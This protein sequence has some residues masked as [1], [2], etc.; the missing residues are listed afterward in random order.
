MNKAIAE[1]IKQSSE[2]ETPVRV[3][4]LD[5]DLT[6]EVADLSHTKSRDCLS[7]LTCSSG[8]PF[9]SAMD[10]GPHGIMR[11]VNYGLRREVL[12]SNTIWLCVGC[13][14][15]SACCPMGIDI[16]AVMDALRHIALREG[17]KPAEPNVLTFHREVLNSIMR[18]GRTHKLEIMLR[19]KLHSGT[20]LKDVG[21]G[22][23]MMAKHKLDLR[24]SKIE[25]PDDLSPLFGPIWRGR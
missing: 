19:Y 18:Y 22:L 21:V 16:A 23:K 12:E 2:R 17:V 6:R 8:C 1:Q 24:P 15:C 5:P 20:W 9:Y 11:R 7:C 25:N 3:N 14:T 13:H 4:E 10:Y